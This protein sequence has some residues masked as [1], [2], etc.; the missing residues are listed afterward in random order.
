M[1]KSGLLSL[2]RGEIQAKIRERLASNYIFNMEY[3]AE[4]ET[5]KFNT[6][7]NFVPQGAGNVVKLT[8][9]LEYKPSENRVRLITMF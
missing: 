2:S 9:S 7:L 1:K 5:M 4:H 8:A 3:I 6:V